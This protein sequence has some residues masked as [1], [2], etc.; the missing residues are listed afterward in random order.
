MPLFEPHLS[1]I[2][3]LSGLIIS[4]LPSLVLFFSGIMKLGGAEQLAGSLE[5]INLLQ[6]M[7]VIG[8]IEILVVIAYWVPR[9]SN[10]GFF[11]VCCF[12]GGIIVGELSMGNFPLPGLMVTTL[13]FIGTFLRKPGMFGF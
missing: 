4:I 3:R 1:K 11:L 13:F 7:E 6:Y 2:R 8:V 5:S 9:F 10:I 12:C